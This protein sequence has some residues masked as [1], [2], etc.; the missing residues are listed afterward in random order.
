M[1]ELDG[2]VVGGEGAGAGY[3]PAELAPGPSGA[4][5]RLGLIG[6]NVV[7]GFFVIVTGFGGQGS[8]EQPLHEM[9]HDVSA[10]HRGSARSRLMLW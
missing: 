6:L 2:P 8:G 5:N 3:A 4:F 1:V 7:R 9:P 10:A